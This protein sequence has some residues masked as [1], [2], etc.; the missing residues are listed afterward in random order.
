VTGQPA[1]AGQRPVTGRAGGL[2]VIGAGVARTGTQS[3]KLGL[4]HLLG[5]PCHHMTEVFADPKQVP[6]WIEAIEGRPVDWTVML[7]GY[8]AIVDWPGASFWPELLAANPGALVVLSVRDAD[9]WYRSAAL[10]VFDIFDYLP[11]EAAPWMQAVRRLLRDR[12]CDR[13]DDRAAMIDAYERHNAEV[14]RGVPAAQ[15][16]EWHPEQGWEPI[17]ARLGLPAPAHSFPAVNSTAEFRA[18]Y[19]MPPVTVST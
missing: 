8:T 4:E 19:Q 12:F 18:D 10:T 7:A 5:A 11:A 15:L 2:A 17:C 14:R 9:T 3:L 1:A 13:F 6:A 16:L